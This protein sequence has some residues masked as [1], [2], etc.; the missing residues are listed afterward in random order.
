[1]QRN[2][3]NKFIYYLG[4][5]DLAEHG[6]TIIVHYLTFNGEPCAVS[7]LV[8]LWSSHNQNHTTEARERVYMQQKKTSK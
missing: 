1:M 5:V 6:A 4:S 8:V 2:E 7:M 3:L